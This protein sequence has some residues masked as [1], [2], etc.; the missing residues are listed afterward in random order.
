MLAKLMNKNSSWET[1][2]EHTRTHTCA[3]THAHTHAES[4]LPVNCKILRTSNNHFNH[5]VL[6]FNLKWI[7]FMFSK[8]ARDVLDDV[9]TSLCS[10]ISSQHETVQDYAFILKSVSSCVQSSVLSL[11]FFILYSNN[12][13][14]IVFNKTS[15]L[16]YILIRFYIMLH[17]RLSQNQTVHSAINKH[18]VWDELKH[19]QQALHTH[20]HTHTHTH[21]YETESQIITTTSHITG[22]QQY[23]CVGKHTHTH[24]H[25]RRQQKKKSWRQEVFTMQ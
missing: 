6:L 19:L 2:S 9:N 20:T 22:T 4:A 3:H 21:S 16:K 25:S 11:C 18:F 15:R 10:L 1:D 23:R 12:T 8:C 14:L 13:R 5:S 7:W 24:T 17:I